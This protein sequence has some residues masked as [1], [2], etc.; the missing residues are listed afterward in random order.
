[1]SIRLVVVDIDGTLLDDDLVLNPQLKRKVNELRCRDVGFT[2]ATGRVFASA[3]LLGEKLGLD[4]PLIANGGAVVQTVRG[5]SLS[6]LVLTPQLVI[7]ALDH[8]ESWPAQRYLLTRECIYAETGGHHAQNYG[9]RLGVSVKVV[10]DLKQLAAES[11]TQLVIRIS[12]QEAGD[13]STSTERMFAGRLAVQQTM[14]HLIE[15]MHQ[16]ASKGKALSLLASALGLASEHIMAV[17]D[18]INDLDMLDVAGL[19]V[20]VGNADPRLWERADIVTKAHCDQGV[21]EALKSFV[22][23]G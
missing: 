13:M 1:M 18:G 22:K 2:L 11:I 3:R 5:Q 10:G 8:T 20:L 14:P 12:S 9:K 15:F 4:L 7:D 19:G 21:I 23:M 16:D 17:G 6:H